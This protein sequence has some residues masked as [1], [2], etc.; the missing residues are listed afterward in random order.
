[1]PSSSS[2]NNNEWS[3]ELEILL[4]TL[5]E[6]IFGYSI[7]KLQTTS[8]MK[9]TSKTRALLLPMLLISHAIA[10]VLEYQDLFEEHI[11]VATETD[12]K[13]LKDISD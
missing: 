3:N 4:K 8:A 13:Q 9:N 7:E 11:A 5:S 6:A 10:S 1:M 2:S 12:L